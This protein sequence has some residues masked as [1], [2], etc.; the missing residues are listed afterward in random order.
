[1]QHSILDKFRLYTQVIINMC[2]K[3]C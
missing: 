3:Q 2:L 1:M